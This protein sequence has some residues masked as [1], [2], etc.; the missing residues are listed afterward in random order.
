MIHKLFLGSI[1]VAA[2]ALAG[3]NKED[4]ANGGIAAPAAP[5]KAVPA[6]NGGDWSTVV[7]ATPEGGFIMGNPGAGVKLVE[8]ASM[9]CPHCREF[10]EEGVKPL[11]DNYVKSGRVSYEFRNFVMNPYDMAAS[12]VARCAG[13]SGFFGLTRQLYADQPDWIAKAQS[14]DPAKMQALSALPANQQLAEVARLAGFP[15]YAAMRGLPSAKLNACLAD[16]DAPTKLVQMS[17]D[18]TTAFPEFPGTPSFLIN[19]KMVEIKT[20]STA[21]TQLEAA[22]KTAIGG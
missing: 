18:V 16:P 12:I 14:A 13:P 20:G 1:A 7:S 11:I 15:E 19:G 10:D 22:L 3:C 2:L 5:V 17:T 9:T 6:P 21:W 8:F 4:S